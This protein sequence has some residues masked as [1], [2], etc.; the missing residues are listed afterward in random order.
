MPDARHSAQQ[1]DEAGRYLRLALE[2]RLE[3]KL[4]GDTFRSAIDVVWGHRKSFTGPLAAAEAKLRA[5]VAEVAE[6]AEPPTGR[7]KRLVAIV[8]KLVRL[9]GMRLTRW[10][11][12][13]D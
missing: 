8:D 9:R 1:I 7:P 5:L 11:T 12:S 3:G 2:H 6:T 10:R 4:E 13:R